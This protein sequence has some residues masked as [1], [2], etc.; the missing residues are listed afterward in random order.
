MRV[1]DGGNF[2]FLALPFDVCTS[3]VLHVAT[4]NFLL[5]TTHFFPLCPF[6]VRLTFF[7]GRSTVAWSVVLMVAIRWLLGL[8]SWYS[9]GSVGIIVVA[10]QE[11]ELVKEEVGFD[12]GS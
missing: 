3:S 6:A 7:Q 2:C 12:D 5:K 10:R 8:T 1:I 4:T 11:R 9:G